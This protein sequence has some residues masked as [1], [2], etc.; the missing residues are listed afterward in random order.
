M[1]ACSLLS[2]RKAE[3]ISQRTR[4]RRRIK[5]G[6][7][8]AENKVRD[9]K[10]PARCGPFCVRGWPVYQKDV[11]RA[12]TL[13]LGRRGAGSRLAV[14]WPVLTH[15]PSWRTAVMRPALINLSR[16]DFRAREQVSSQQRT[17]T[18]MVLT[19]SDTFHTKIFGSFVGLQA[20]GWWRQVTGLPS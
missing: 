8:P 15:T 4:R 11:T 7:A 9:E 2:A 18:T 17:S 16:R 14:E 5:Q 3:T 1:R 20:E 10:R 6:G 13:F 19:S 12:V